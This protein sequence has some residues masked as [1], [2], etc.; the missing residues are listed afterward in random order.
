MG[1]R[2]AEAK[3]KA[4]A[5]KAGKIKARANKRKEQEQEEWEEEQAVQDE[6]VEVEETPVK[7]KPRGGRK[8]TT[9]STTSSSEKAT[10][11]ETR[12]RRPPITEDTS[13][14]DLLRENGN[15]KW[16]SIDTYDDVMA[17]LQDDPSPELMKEVSTATELLKLHKE[18]RQLVPV[19]KEKLDE[20]PASLPRSSAEAAP[21]GSPPPADSLLNGVHSARDAAG[22]MPDSPLPHDDDDSLLS[23]GKSA[24]QLQS[25]KGAFKEDIR[26]RN[27]EQV[28]Q[29]T[30]K[31]EDQEGCERQ[32][33]EPSRRKRSAKPQRPES[34]HMMLQGLAAMVTHLASSKQAAA[35]TDPQPGAEGPPAFP[36]G[37]QDYNPPPVPEPSAQSSAGTKSQEGESTQGPA[38]TVAAGVCEVSTTPSPPFPSPEAAA[39]PPPPPEAP[40]GPTLLAICDAPKP[41]ASPQDATAA[42]SLPGSAP[43]P[44]PTAAEA[45]AA[46]AHETAPV[47]PKE[48]ISIAEGESQTQAEQTLPEAESPQLDSI[49]KYDQHL[50]EKEMRE[51]EKEAKQAQAQAEEA[52]PHT[53]TMV[54]AA[55]GSSGQDVGASVPASSV[56]PPVQPAPPTTL[57]PALAAAVSA[58]SAVSNVQAPATAAPAAPAQLAALR[59][60][61][62]TTTAPAV[63]APALI[64]APSSAPKP[65]EAAP[66]PAAPA[67][68]PTTQPVAAVA[69]A[70][71]ADA[72]GTKTLEQVQ[73]A[74]QMATQMMAAKK[75]SKDRAASHRKLKVMLRGLGVSGSAPS[76][77]EAES[78][79]ESQEESQPESS[80]SEEED[81]DARPAC[82]RR[83]KGGKS[84]N[85]FAVRARFN[86]RM[87]RKKLDP[88]IKAAYKDP[89]N[90]GSLFEKFV[91]LNEDLSAM[92]QQIKREKENENAVQEDYELLDRTALLRLHD[93]ASVD[94]LVKAKY[95][96]G[97]WAPNK[98]FPSRRD[99]DLFW[100]LT[101][102]HGYRKSGDTTTYTQTAELNPMTTPNVPEMGLE[103]VEIAPPRRGAAF[104]KDAIPEVKL[105]KGSGGGGSSKPPQQKTK[106]PAPCKAPHL[107][108]RDGLLKKLNGAINAAQTARN[109]LEGV[110]NSTET[111]ENLEAAVEAARKTLKDVKKKSDEEFTERVHQTFKKEA[112][113]VLEELED[114]IDSAKNLMRKRK[115]KST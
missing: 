30:S 72:A 96:S 41:E 63:A 91:L 38:T 31:R 6:V 13:V 46:E 18:M 32:G 88:S 100:V 39:A 21:P 49:G 28:Q 95:E 110:K 83:K 54:P 23:V 36:P 60:P 75:G 74:L 97:D 94:F 50:Q 24:S 106:P 65:A 102:T 90:R 22:K 15:P 108:E 62:T 4:Q 51:L 68:A 79:D 47:H 53:S 78:A 66:A 93:A 56:P 99:K 107:V 48:N 105:P 10:P 52:P 12:K 11:P 103:D 64:S 80:S 87:K 40:A 98:D 115:R 101:K 104:A 55:A 42:E 111:I 92:A 44:P 9:P 25:I 26:K 81:S 2:R 3:R 89:L 16:K 67:A 85:Y 14:V 59:A 1:G 27:T 5:K 7:K 69:T 45:A 29:E 35:L 77:S 37:P 76:G 58:A 71:E 43:P 114:N 70:A 109:D 57:L 86:R 61:P 17:I 34:M 33:Q 84:M 20:P 19:K 82:Q 8:S 112:N 113:G 73:Q